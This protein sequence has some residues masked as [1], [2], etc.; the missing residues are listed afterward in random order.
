MSEESKMRWPP[1]RNS[2]RDMRKKS[3]NPE[4]V[5]ASPMPFI[6]SN[7]VSYF[8]RTA[9][10][11]TSSQSTFLTSRAFITWEASGEISSAV[12]S[13]PSCCKAR[14]W[15]PAPAPISRILPRHCCKAIHS[16]SG[17]SSIERK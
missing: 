2:A 8:S 10:R 15:L 3:R 7:N 13:W 9:S 1:G 11:K 14:A 5:P 6:I 4:R 12:T 16:S 17:I